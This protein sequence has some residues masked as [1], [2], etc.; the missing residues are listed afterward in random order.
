MAARD[1]KLFVKKW[2]NSAVLLIGL[3]LIII[4]LYVT[5]LGC[6]IKHMTGISCP[7][8]GMTRAVLEAVQ[9]HFTAAFHYH[10][11]FWTLPLIVALCGLQ[12]KLSKRLVNGIALT[13]VA[14]FLMVYAVRLINPQNTVVVADWNSGWVM[15]RFR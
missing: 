4:I 14:A 13:L 2:K 5:G 3:V 6:P 7:G 11:L 12:E 10:P 1:G 15:K 8:C 9:L